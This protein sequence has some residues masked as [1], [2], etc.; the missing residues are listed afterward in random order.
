VVAVLHLRSYLAVYEKIRCIDVYE[1]SI[2][3]DCELIRGKL[4]A[5][6]M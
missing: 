5:Y 4:T 6:V 3:I 2:M 1:V